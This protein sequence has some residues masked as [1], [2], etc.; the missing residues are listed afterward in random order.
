MR[1]SLYWYWPFSRFRLSTPVSPRSETASTLPLQWRMILTSRWL[2]T[3]KR[4]SLTFPIIQ[5]TVYGEKLCV[6]CSWECL[7][8]TS[9]I[10]TDLLTSVHH[11]LSW[12]VGSLR[13]FA[14]SLKRRHLWS[15]LCLLV[16]P[17]LLWRAFS[18]LPTSF[19]LT[20]TFNS[21]QHVGQPVLSFINEVVTAAT[22]L[23]YLGEDKR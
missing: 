16:K 17:G 23:K 20:T 11:G 4:W 5:T 6:F 8:W 7:Y 3:E 2:F 14:V 18:L 22:D 19:Q 15:I 21:L 9:S 1:T 10:M 13:T 12:H